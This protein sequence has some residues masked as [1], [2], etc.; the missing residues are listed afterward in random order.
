MCGR[1]LLIGG[2]RG[3][4]AT[5]DW[6]L[7]KLGCELHLKETVRDVQYVAYDVRRVKAWLTMLCKSEIRG[8]NSPLYAQPSCFSESLSVE[9]H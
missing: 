2:R 4:V 1:Y 7:G 3:H 5:F 9:A 8:G 6:K